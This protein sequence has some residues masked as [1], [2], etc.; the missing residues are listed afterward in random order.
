MSRAYKS[1]DTTVLMAFTF[2]RLPVAALL[3]F[4]L[5]GEVPEL[6]VWLGAAVI[7]AS[8]IYIAHRESVAGKSRP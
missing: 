8:S 6:W 5:F 1:A 4:A 3:G 7:A 2:L